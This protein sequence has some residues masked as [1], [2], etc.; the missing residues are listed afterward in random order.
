MRNQVTWFQALLGEIRLGVD[1]EEVGRASD[2]RRG[3]GSSEDRKRSKERGSIE[4]RRVI[5]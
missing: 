5:F 2:L 3:R 1:R 4:V